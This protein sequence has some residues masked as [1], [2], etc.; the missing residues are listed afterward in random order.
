MIVICR[1]IDTNQGGI[2]VYPLK[3]EV[4]DR[5]MHN[6]SIRARVNPELRYF[7]T[8]KAHWD[9]FQKEITRVLKRKVVNREHID[10]LGCI[11]E[12]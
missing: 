8:T 5:L 7:V 3:T 9:G 11:T 10:R 6:L 12:L 2:A 4:T 1:E